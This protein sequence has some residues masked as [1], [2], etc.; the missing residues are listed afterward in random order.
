MGINTI[1]TQQFLIWLTAELILLGGLGLFGLMRVFDPK[2]STL[3]H[4]PEGRPAFGTGVLSK[5]DVPRG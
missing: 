4:P 5:P 1:G 3:P 2:A